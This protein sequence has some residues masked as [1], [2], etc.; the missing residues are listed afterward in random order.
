MDITHWKKHRRQEDAWEAELKREQTTQLQQ[1]QM[2]VQMQTFSNIMNQNY[3]NDFQQ[4]FNHDEWISNYN[5]S[6]HT[7]KK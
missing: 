5:Q 6:Q 1:Q 3:T 2:F 7:K 4:I